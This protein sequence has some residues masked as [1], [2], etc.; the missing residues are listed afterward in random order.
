MKTW[1]PQKNIYYELHLYYN[2]NFKIIQWKAKINSVY[3]DV[4]LTVEVFLI[5]QSGC[6]CGAFKLFSEWFESKEQDFI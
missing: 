6:F 1:C 5:L 3:G 4:Y 2:F